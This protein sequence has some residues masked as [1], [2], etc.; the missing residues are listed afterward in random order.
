M[1]FTG[2]TD[3][4]LVSSKSQYLVGRNCVAWERPISRQIFWDHS[5]CIQVPAVSPQGPSPQADE[6]PGSQ[7]L[8]AP[9]GAVCTRAVVQGLPGASPTECPPFAVAV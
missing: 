2:V 8:P 4:S 7:G 5:E 1:E 3:S 6:G 9:W